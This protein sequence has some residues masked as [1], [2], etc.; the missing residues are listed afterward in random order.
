MDINFLKNFE[1][2]TQHLLKES[3]FFKKQQEI[4]NMIVNQSFNSMIKQQGEI[5]KI[6]QIQLDLLK[7]N[8]SIFSNITQDL[9]KN[10]GIIQQTVE[11]L[12]YEH[13]QFLKKE[14]ELTSLINAVNKTKI[15]LNK[16][17]SIKSMVQN[18]LE[19]NQLLKI[20]DIQKQL[21]ENF[22]KEFQIKDNLDIKYEDI[23]KINK[24][25]E[26]KE[27]FSKKDLLKLIRFLEILWLFYSIYSALNPD[28]LEHIKT[29]QMINS[30]DNKISKSLKQELYYEI[31]KQVNVRELA[32][33]KSKKI[34]V[35]NPKQ[36]LLIIQNKPYWLQVE[37]FDEIKN[38]TI[39]GW[40]SKKYTKRLD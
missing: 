25:I 22:S 36:K 4:S 20:G 34:A 14:T 26:Q 38:E 15:T 16:D 5:S 28:N 19:E 10:K 2:V 30:L 31:T 6:A 3:E 7:N 9:F 35:T 37:Y 23:E 17:N 32:D 24:K 1:N 12:I 8:S 40:V 33:S 18:L 29:Q 39:I 11:N 21:L 13:N 27:A